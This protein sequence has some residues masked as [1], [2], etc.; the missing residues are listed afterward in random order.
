MI[1]GGV[2]DRLEAVLSVGVGGAGGRQ[3]SVEAV[4]DTGYS[5]FLTLPRA[6]T[7]M[8]AFLRVGRGAAT[9]ADGSEARFDVYHAVVNWDGQPLA[10]QVDQV[11][12][13]PLLGM[14][15]LEQHELRTP[16]V[17][18]GQVTVEPLP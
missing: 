17:E 10:T 5:G 16:V 3:H 4:I 13:T 8:L 1:R 11:D 18:G 9:L 12:T 2:N 15:M 6:L 14:A 7:Q